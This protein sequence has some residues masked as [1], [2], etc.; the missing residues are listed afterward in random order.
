M[1]TRSAFLAALFLTC[2]ILFAEEW[3]TFTDKEGRSF[4]GSVLSVDK[5]AKTFRVTVKDSGN[6]ATVPFGKLSGKDLEYVKKW[7]EPAPEETTG[8]ED[9]DEGDLPS[10]LYPRTKDEIDDRIK[11]IRKRPAPNGIDKL[12]QETVNELN[13]YRYL[14]GVPDDVE[15]DKQM[16]KEATE[17]AIACKDFGGLSHDLGHFTNKVNLSTVGDI[18]N[19]PKQYINDAGANNREHR[20]HR[21]WCLNPPMG[22]TG[23]GTAGAKYSAMWAMDSSGSKIRDSWSYPGKG[24]FPKEF[25]HGNAWTLYLPGNA[26]PTEDLTV[27]VFKLT[28]RPQKAFSSTGEIPGRA[29]PVKFVFSYQNAINFEPEEDPITGRGI[30]WVRIKGGGLREGYVVDLY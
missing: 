10:S 11:E 17:A 14:C 22:K 16:I 4:E 2:T 23:F 9:S 6:A 12:Q 19:T 26:P 15:A 24:F 5:E 18:F 1:K 21:R 29:L 30:Y 13:V 20:G 7:K 25:L 8:W 27:E 28:T 3:R